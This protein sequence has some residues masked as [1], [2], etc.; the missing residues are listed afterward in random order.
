MLFV[1]FA[2]EREGTWECS[3]KQN[4]ETTTTAAAAATAKES[5]V[6]L[7]FVAASDSDS[8]WAESQ[9]K[10]E[11]EEEKLAHDFRL[12]S[13]SQQQQMQSIERE[14]RKVTRLLIAAAV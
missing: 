5:V 2:L 9:L 11:E 14:G 6:T 12:V 3:K 8:D 13:G 1:C 7:S 4:K 10:K